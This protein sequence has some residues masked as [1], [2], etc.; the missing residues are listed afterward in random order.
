MQLVQQALDKAKISLMNRPDSVFFSTICFSLKH[1]W[2][3]SIPTAATNG[4][5]ILFNPP[6]FMSLSPEERVFLLL[7]ETMHV[8]FLHMDRLSTRDHKK[9]NVAADHVINL[10]LI[11]RGYKMP[12]IGLADPMYAD[13]STE[14]VYAILPDL[15][16]ETV[17]LDIQPSDLPPEEIKNIIE[18]IIV[19]ASINSKMQGDKEGTI[20]GEIEIFLN[21]L[22]KPKLPWQRILQKNIQALFKD[23]YTFKK[24]NRR[25][26]PEYYLPSLTGERLMD[27]SIALDISGSVTDDEFHRFVSEVAHILKMLQPEKITLVQFENRITSVTT[28]KNLKE[29]REVKFMGRGGTKID[30]VIN[31]ANENKPRMLLVFSDGDFRFSRLDSKIP[32]TWLIYDNESF[33]APFG[34]VIHYTMD[35]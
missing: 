15:T 20:P 16:N 10:M 27:L 17:D 35:E 30:P 18:D 26:F 12:K 3:T 5:R 8:A 22:L 9:W 19:R 11:K 14:Q 4:L 2:D 25:Y 23:N 31:W 1:I 21:G 33:S 34:K 29:L 13:M 6:F 32:F 28:I 7:H 24:P